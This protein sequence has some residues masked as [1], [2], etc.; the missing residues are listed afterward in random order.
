MIAKLI[1]AVAVLVPT[2]VGVAVGWRVG[3]GV[4]LI[5]LW[6]RS[7]G[8]FIDGESDEFDYHYS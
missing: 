6:G 3:R 2:C 5:E 8:R 7:G 4:D 1:A